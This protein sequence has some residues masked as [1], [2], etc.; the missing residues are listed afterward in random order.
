MLRAFNASACDVAKCIF[1][2]YMLETLAVVY[3]RQVPPQVQ[4]ISVFLRGFVPSACLKN[5]RTWAIEAERLF[6]SP[7][8]VSLSRRFIS[9]L[10]QMTVRLSAGRRWDDSESYHIFRIL[11]TRSG[12]TFYRDAIASEISAKDQKKK[13][14]KSNRETRALMR[15]G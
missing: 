11:G 4:H 2:R 3:Y 6:F 7:L 12:P 10:I 13:R 5:I 15:E 14:E 9:S 8:S 1:C